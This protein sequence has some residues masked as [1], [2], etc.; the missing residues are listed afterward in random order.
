MAFE[1]SEDAIYNEEGQVALRYM[2]QATALASCPGQGAK[3][4]IFTTKANVSMA[5]ID[6]DD[7]ECMLQVTAGCCGGKKKNVIFYADETHVRRWEAGGG[8]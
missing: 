5:Y 3:E 2:K 6:E 7:V 8:R 1:I 4:Y